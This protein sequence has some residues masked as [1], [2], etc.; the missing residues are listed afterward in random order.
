MAR[1]V[2]RLAPG[3]STTKADSGLAIRK[4]QP[5]KPPWESAVLGE[6][7]G[8]LRV[9][10]SEQGDDQQTSRA[11]LILPAGARHRGGS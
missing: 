4:L 11:D 6:T 3:A 8:L 2:I 5:P 1:M 9:I 7:S 10:E